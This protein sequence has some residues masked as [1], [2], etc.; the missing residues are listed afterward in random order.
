MI[1]VIFSMAN[2][3]GVATELRVKVPAA[4]QALHMESDWWILQIKSDEM[5]NSLLY[6]QFDKDKFGQA[7]A[8]Q[9]GR[10]SRFE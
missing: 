10:V 9:D 2:V 7:D 6:T 4:H 8:D 5:Q 1:L 3:V